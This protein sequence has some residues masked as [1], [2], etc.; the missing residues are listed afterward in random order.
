M[1]TC[2]E[3]IQCLKAIFGTHHCTKNRHEEGNTWVMDMRNDKYIVS[4]VVLG[5]HFLQKAKRRIKWET[6]SLESSSCI[7]GDRSWRI[8]LYSLLKSFS[9][10]LECELFSSNDEAEEDGAVRRS[11]S[12]YSLMD[13]STAYWERRV[14]E[15][16]EKKK[17]K[18]E[19]MNGM[20]KR[21]IKVSYV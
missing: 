3:G 21:A 6:A 13:R 18:T 4:G 20:G 9:L 11:A 19:K 8:W 17:C 7:N 16:N 10:E 14:W 12:S 1:H 2:T 15:T 5:A